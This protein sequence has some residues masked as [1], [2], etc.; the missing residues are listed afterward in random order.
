LHELL[1]TVSALRDDIVVESEA[2]HNTWEARIERSAFVP[3][4]QNLAAYLAL[5]RRDVRTLQASLMRWGLS[6]LGRRGS[7]V[8]AIST[9]CCLTAGACP[10]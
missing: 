9:I 5:R 10:A 3:S 4:A 6:S 7:R 1:S 8:I 2:L